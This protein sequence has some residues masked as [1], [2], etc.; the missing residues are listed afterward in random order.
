MSSG[1]YQDRG[2]SQRRLAAPAECQGAVSPAEGF[3]GVAVEA[4]DHV[5]IE[6]C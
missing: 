5:L 4:C 2:E 6:Y 1:K 3:D